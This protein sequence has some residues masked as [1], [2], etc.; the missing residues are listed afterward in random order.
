MSTYF[1]YVAVGE[2][3]G[4]ERSQRVVVSR[5]RFS[6]GSIAS[7]GTA[8]QTAAQIE[9]TGHILNID[10]SYGRPTLT[11]LVHLTN[12]VHGPRAVGVPYQYFEQGK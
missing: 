10:Y 12:T 8:I 11:L 1:V 7:S 9:R 5:T 3:E 2:G 4:E 6:F